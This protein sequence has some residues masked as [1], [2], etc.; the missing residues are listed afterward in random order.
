[1]VGKYVGGLSWTSTQAGASGVDRGPV[2]G[3]FNR[4]RIN[5]LVVA[6]SATG[7]FSTFLGQGNGSFTFGSSISSAF[8]D[9]GED[10]LAAKLDNDGNLDVVT[11]A[12][13]G[14]NPTLI[15]FGGSSDGKLVTASAKFLSARPP[16][17]HLAL[18]DFDKDG[19]IDVASSARTNNGVELLA[20]L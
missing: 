2:I 9:L 17:R 15:A 10:L 13:A 1:M 4:D 5:D 12:D 16:A 11:L 20:P 18:A 19:R 6:N 3:D 8:T 14:S 7:V